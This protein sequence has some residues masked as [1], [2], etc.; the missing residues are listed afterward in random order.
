[1]EL[2]E[3]HSWDVQFDADGNPIYRKYATG[4]GFLD[5]PLRENLPMTGSPNFQYLVLDG[6]YAGYCGYSD[7]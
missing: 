1:M 5:I 6:T 7:L 3:I 2:V 4:G